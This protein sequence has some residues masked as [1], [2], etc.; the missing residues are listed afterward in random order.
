VLCVGSPA[1]CLGRHL[2][3]GYGETAVEIGQAL[4]LILYFEEVGNIQPL[5]YYLVIMSE[6]LLQELMEALGQHPI[7]MVGQPGS[8]R[9][10]IL[11]P[12]E[13]MEIPRGRLRQVRPIYGA[14]VR[15]WYLKARNQLWWAFADEED[16]SRHWLLFHL[17]SE[18]EHSWLDCLRFRTLRQPQRGHR[19]PAL[20]GRR[21]SVSYS[22]GL[23]GQ[24][25]LVAEEGDDV[26]WWVFYLEGPENQIL[27]LTTIQMVMTPQ[28]MEE[29]VASAPGA[30]V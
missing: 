30:E 14:I 28:V 20:H 29:T 18:G 19:L 17:W 7:V 12:A 10:A 6:Q 4:S 11:I 22:Q 2:P 3:I 15:T 8:E 27:H 1:R 13:L 9:P 21:V 26:V 23:E 16:G 25:I 5:P 24:L